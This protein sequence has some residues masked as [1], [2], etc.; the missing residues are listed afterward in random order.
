MSFVIN[1]DTPIVIDRSLTVMT[2]DW[3]QVRSPSRAARRRRMGHPQRIRF[4]QKPSNEVYQMGG[5]LIMHPDV[6]ARV[7][8]QIGEAVGKQMK[9][10]GLWW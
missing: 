6:M 10:K 8:A 5:K 7:K 9:E 3:S 2:E 1:S 4:V